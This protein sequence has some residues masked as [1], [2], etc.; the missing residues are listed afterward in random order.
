MVDA[1][2]PAARRVASDAVGVAGHRDPDEP[3]PEYCKP[4]WYAQA[5]QNY[6]EL[7]AA[8]AEA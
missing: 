4:Q 2:S 7:E 5:Q 8:A 3:C 6:R 1:A